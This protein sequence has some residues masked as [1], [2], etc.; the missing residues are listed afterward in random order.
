MTDYHTKNTVHPNYDESKQMKVAC[1]KGKKTIEVELHPRPMVTDPN[2]AILRVTSTCICGSDLHLYLGAMPGMS[3]GDIMGHEFM[4][5]ID[6]VGANVTNYKVG[7]RV[8]ASFDIACGD[9]SYCKKGL[10]TSCDYTN[11]SKAQEFLY[12]H[13]T[14]GL[15]GYSSMTGAYDGGQAEYAR[16]PFADVNL[17]KVPEGMDDNKVIFLSDILPTAWHATEMGEVGK[18][19]VVAIW[20]AGPVGILAAQCAQAR[21]ADRVILI[22]QIPFRLKFAQEKLPGVE[23]INYKEKN[24]L[25]ALQEM[26]PN[27]P[28]V[29]IEAVGFHYC[30]SWL[31]SIETTL[32]LETDPADML[33]EMINATRKG[34]RIS[35]VGV[36]SGF[37]NHFNIGA[38]MEKSLTMRG[39][40]CPVQ[41]YWKYLLKAIESGKLDPTIVITH[42]LPLDAAPEAYKTFNEKTDGCVKVILKP[43]LNPTV[44]PVNPTTVTA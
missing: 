16:V 1:W 5:V 4:G 11:P 6:S 38:L 25:K 7:D 40:Q 12:G 23:V 20:G 14:A 2:D 21:G 43:T 8:V 28:D 31:H 17:L 18:G 29:S 27:G 32:M 19:D 26:V 35:I 10:Y 9:C 13:R 33:N 22:D 42:E 36:Y 34:G 24:T 30:K 39:G 44:N 37:V 15:H 41:K 3:K